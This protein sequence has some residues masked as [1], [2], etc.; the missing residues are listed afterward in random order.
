MAWNSSTMPV[1]LSRRDKRRVMPPF[2]FPVGQ[3]PSLALFG[4]S[5]SEETVEMRAKE[6]K[7]LMRRRCDM[8]STEDGF[9]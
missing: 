5:K 1:K 2:G 9:H 6:V 3:E 8:M 7:F 4:C